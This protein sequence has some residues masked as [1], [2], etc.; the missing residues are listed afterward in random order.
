MKEK[1]EIIQKEVSEISQNDKIIIK[2][3][4]NIENEKVQ[5]LN[6]ENLYYFFFSKELYNE[7]G[8]KLLNKEKYIPFLNIL[9]EYIKEKNDFILLFFK[10]IDINLIKVVFNGYLTS[11]INDTQKKATLLEIIKNIIPLFFSKNL[12]YFVYNKLSKI[13]RQFHTIKDKEILFDKFCKLFDIWNL[14][15][16][17]KD[18]TKVNSDYFAIIGNKELL[19]MKNSNENQY[20]YNN[21]DIF[22]EFEDGIYGLN[23]VNKDC[24][25]VKVSYVLDGAKMLIL[26]LM[27]NQLGI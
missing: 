14:L 17:I 20:N 21:V 11:D 12:F 2:I 18:K 27:K 16:N 1:N 13:F 19:L 9:N 26:G 3:G 5:E 6:E 8:T 15:Y 23:N 24:V 22:I 7:K 10:K 4:E 25:L